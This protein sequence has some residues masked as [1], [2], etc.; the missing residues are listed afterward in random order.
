MDR[1][2]KPCVFDY[3][4][5]RELFYALR[6]RY[7]LADYTVCGHSWAGRALFS[8]SIGTGSKRVLLTGGFHGQEW[9]T[10]LILL[11]FFERMCGA[12]ENKTRLCGIR[13]ANALTDRTV[14]IIPCVNQ[15]GVQIALKGASGAGCYA[16][17][18]HRISAGNF[19][20]WNAN[21]RGVDINH[22]FD[23][24]WEI[25]RQMEINEGIRGPAPRRYGGSAPE[26]EPETGALTAL[27]RQ[28]NFRHALAL[29]SQGEEIYWEYGENTPER[30]HLMAKI[31]SASSEY[32]LVKNEG[33][34]SHGGFKD[35][36][37]E[38]FSRPAFTI[39]AGL[40]K[41]P[42]PLSDFEGIYSKIE[43]MLLLSVLM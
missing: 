17:L 20:D 16:G 42:L 4:K 14:V 40:G 11:R 34:C 9:M 22:N 24:G 26:S 27:C 12:L 7:T 21:A 13:L 35:W 36:F 19:S 29:H 5:N 23:A 1:I 43:E 6:Q 3:E 41:N 28:V 33:L 15:D 30:S 2:V 18:C 25:L 8:L 32:K 31:L 10:S 38:E 37:I 39:E